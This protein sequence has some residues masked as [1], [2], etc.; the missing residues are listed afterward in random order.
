MF[1]KLTENLEGVDMKCSLLIVDDEPKMVKYLSRRL[2]N[3]GYEVRT[4]SSG[5]EA[6]AAIANNPFTVILLDI[7]MPEMN[8]IETLKKIMET[9]PTA[10]VI[11]L[12][13]HLSEQIAAEG[14]KLG[15]FDLVMKP[16][17][18]KELIGKIDL[19][20]RHQCQENAVSEFSGETIQPEN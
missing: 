1:R 5:Q 12:T 9:T 2:I 7:M 15:A 17:D 4:A 10:A 3:R 13:G 16:F 18:F 19:A 8:G 20:A 6:L 11:L 14:K